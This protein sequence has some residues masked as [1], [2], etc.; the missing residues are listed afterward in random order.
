MNKSR[1]AAIGIAAFFVLGTF[2]LASASALHAGG[3]GAAP[4]APLKIVEPLATSH[5]Q[6]HPDALRASAKAPTVNGHY[7]EG[8]VWGP[9][10]TA[11]VN[12]EIQTQLKVPDQIPSTLSSTNEF[13]YVLL[14]A[15]DNN[16]SYDQIGISDDNGTWG[17]TLSYTYDTSGTGC[18][19]TLAYVFTPDYV[20][21]TQGTTYTFAMVF[22]S[23][24]PGD[25][26]FIVSQGAV[27]LVDLPV[28][29]GGTAFDLQ[30]T[31]CGYYGTTDY[32]E[33]YT[34]Q[35]AVPDSDMHFFGGVYGGS[36]PMNQLVAV[37]SAG[38]PPAG[39]H[40]FGSAGAVVI[41][42]QDSSISF[43][44]VS[45]DLIITSASSASVTFTLSFSP[46]GTGPDVT[47]CFS[48][49]SWVSGVGGGGTFT[50]SHVFNFNVGITAATPSGT[51][52]LDL[53]IYESGVTPS[54][55]GVYSYVTLT[56]VLF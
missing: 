3:G 27:I 5:P 45:Q 32:E 30:N 53:L 20:T 23:A 50:G 40:V 47:T 17:L 46:T 42:N 28:A 16:G 24:F 38:T 37:F 19:G 55:T 25:M 4:S 44:G 11:V 1:W 7:Y 2:G 8:M 49:G 39:V 22:Y 18:S 13:F 52:Y 36:T 41:G 35:Q 31:N 21:L 26:A 29:T 12:S 14:S 9:K 51:Y 34:T 43:Y 56:V 6:P 54:C 33:V 10:K 15:F 48:A